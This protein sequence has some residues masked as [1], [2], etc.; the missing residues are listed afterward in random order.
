MSTDMSGICREHREI[1]E[2]IG[3]DAYK[4]L[5]YLCGGELLYIPK[6]SGLTRSERNKKLFKEFDGKNYKILAK[7]YSLSERRVREI[8]NEEKSRN[9]PH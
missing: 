6:M 1:A 5:A 8:I 4:K 3:V 7:K 2:Y 9:K